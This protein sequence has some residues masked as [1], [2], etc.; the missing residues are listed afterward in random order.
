MACLFTCLFG[1]TLYGAL[2]GLFGVAGKLKRYN[3]LDAWRKKSEKRLEF[4]SVTAKIYVQM[5][6][7]RILLCLRAFDKLS[8]HEK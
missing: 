6:K 1:S 5:W 7:K 3:A 8:K 2:N 4:A